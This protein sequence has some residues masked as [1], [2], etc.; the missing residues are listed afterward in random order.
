[1]SRA[2]ASSDGDLWRV[3]VST[4]STRRVPLRFGRLP[5]L[6]EV[7]QTDTSRTGSTPH[8]RMFSFR[9]T[10]ESRLSRHI[11][12]CASLRD[13][14]SGLGPRADTSRLLSQATSRC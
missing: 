7:R 6:F 2:H 13:S 11:S 10:P 8:V 9:T 5:R 1:M 12:G 14:G 3:R 4:V